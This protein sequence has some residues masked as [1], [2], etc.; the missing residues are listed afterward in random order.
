MAMALG[1]TLALTAV[2]IWAVDVLGVGWTGEWYVD[3]R[4][5]DG[6]ARY[7]ADGRRRMRMSLWKTSARFGFV[8]TFGIGHRRWRRTDEFYTFSLNMT[9]RLIAETH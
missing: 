5:A 6:P 9:D 4:I 2:G 3:E 7:A 8:G 1:V